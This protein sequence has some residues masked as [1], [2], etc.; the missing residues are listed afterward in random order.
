MTDEQDKPSLVTWRR[1][2]EAAVAF[3]DTAPWNWMYD[4]D[5]F[6]VRDP[7]TGEI[8]YCCILGAAGEVFG[9]TVYRGSEGL[10]VYLDLESRQI[11]GNDPDLLFIQRC[12]MADFEDRKML[13]KADLDVIRSLGLTF[14]GAK[15]WPQFRSYIPGYFPWHLTEGEACFLTAALEQALNVCLR[16]RE[17]PSLF[18]SPSGYEYLVRTAKEEQGEWVWGDE[19]LEP[20]PVEEKELSFE[21]LDED[22]LARIKEQ[23]SPSE[24]VWEGDF[25]YLDSPV[26]EEGRPYYPRFFMW[27]DARSGCIIGQD[28]NSPD[29]PITLLRDSLIEVLERSEIYPCQIRV[30]KPEAVELVAPLAQSLNI[31]LVKAKRLAAIDVF[32]R[33]IPDFFRRM[34]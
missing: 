9:L 32:R 3:K 5:L 12:L 17:N 26:K 29:E 13:D 14:R 8:G 34:P 16:F 33:A 1:L 15:A 18:S 27:A 19:W 24:E 7:L 31:K 4:S 23:L 28:L 21:P 25:F 2:Y 10:D 20:E 6:G 11:G 22:R 30:R